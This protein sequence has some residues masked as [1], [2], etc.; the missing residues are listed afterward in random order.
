MISAP[1]PQNLEFG[2]ESAGLSTAYDAFQ[3]LCSAIFP[4]SAK[5]RLLAML[6]AYMDASGS[7]GISPYLIVCGYLATKEQWE[8]FQIDWKAMLPNNETFHMTD[9]IAF[10]GEF[11]RAK[12][13]DEVRQKKLLN[14]ALDVIAKH[15]ICGVTGIV[16]ISD[17]EAYYPAGKKKR[18]KIKGRKKFAQEYAIAGLSCVIGISRLAK[19]LN[20]SR[21]IKYIFEAGDDGYAEI[22]RAL[23]LASDDK[24]QR[25]HFLVGGWGAERKDH[26]CQLHPADILAHQIRLAA[27]KTRT[28][29]GVNLDRDVIRGLIRSQD[30][31]LYVYDREN[32]PV[33]KTLG[34]LDEE[35]KN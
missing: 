9:L 7:D 21:P 23:K 1:F 12:G 22:E 31:W 3:H 17:C 25:E 33:L 11:S 2:G 30:R 32:L 28:A 26:L 13:W 34:D 16:N 24:E 20:Y 8:Q 6:T 10:Q 4:L 19:R 5:E 14:T 29:E 27:M 18:P 35:L 15:T